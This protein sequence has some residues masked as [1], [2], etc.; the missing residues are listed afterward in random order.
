M[1]IEK[2]KNIK[3]SKQ[4]LRIFSFISAGILFIFAVFLYSKKTG[5]FLPLFLCAL[6]VLISGIL[7]PMI[8]Y[9]FQ[10]IWL[11]LA[12]TAEWFITVILL[13]GVYYLIFGLLGMLFKILNKNFLDIKI[14]TEQTSYWQNQ[15]QSIKDQDS[16]KKQY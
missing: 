8:I 7:Y 11:G 5:Y 10:K 9:P 15:K 3:S 1:L 12:F 13:S 14:N 16:Y 6:I 4:D 2:I